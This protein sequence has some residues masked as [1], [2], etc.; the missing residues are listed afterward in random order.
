MNNSHGGVRYPWALLNVLAL[1]LTT[2]YF[3]RIILA[4]AAPVLG[5]EMKLTPQSLGILL[6]AVYWTY[7]FCQ[8]GLGWLVDRYDM[9]KIY[10]A[11]LALWS[12]ATLSIGV[13]HSFAVMFVLLL[14][15]GVGESA[16]IPTAARV[17]LASFPETRRGVVNSVVDV[18]GS[19]V[20]PALGALLG[21]L[22][23][24]ILGWRHLFQAAG[25]AALLWIV[26]WLMLAPRHSASTK[27]A[28]AAGIRWID[29]IR[30]RAVLATCLQGWGGSYVWAF[31]VTWLPSYLYHERHF[32][33]HRMAVWSALPH[34]IMAVTSLSCGVLSDHLIGRGRPGVHTRKTFT[35]GGL[36]LIALLLPLVLIH[37]IEWA[38]AGLSLASVAHGIYGSNVWALTQTLA[39][40]KATGSWAGFQNAFANTSGIIAPVLTGLIVA[41]TGRFAWA[42]IAASTACLIGAASSW[43]LVHPSDANLGMNEMATVST[44]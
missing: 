37:R 24:A 43:F 38:L 20:G 23:I 28:D 19:R 42:F 30:R 14:L 3:L 32:S 8:I 16:A 26:P 22:L 33:L 44:A 40:R 5:P 34:V 21:G 29:L 2:T 27:K 11:A 17:L 18:S 4:V 31:L 6:S 10:A 36:L 39:G 25:V 9:R 12:L 13:T 41:H 35:A 7:A 15:M 1:A